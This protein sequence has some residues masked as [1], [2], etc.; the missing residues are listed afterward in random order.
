MLFNKDLGMVL[1]CLPYRT[2]IY[3]SPLSQIVKIDSE[4]GK[5]KEREKGEGMVQKLDLIR[6]KKI[7]TE[8]S[9]GGLQPQISSVERKCVFL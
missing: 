2:Q 7:D 1:I 4:M 5:E 9:F 6:G 3:T 8:S